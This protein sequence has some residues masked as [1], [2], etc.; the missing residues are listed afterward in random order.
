[1]FAYKEVQKMCAITNS[2]NSDTYQG[3]YGLFHLNPNT[4]CGLIGKSI[5]A[6]KYQ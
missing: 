6:G 2:A 4:L 1:M 5:L 3:S